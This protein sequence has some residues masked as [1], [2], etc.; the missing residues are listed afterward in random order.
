[1]TNN[2]TISI[3]NPCNENWNNMTATE[4]GKFCGSCQKNV[5]DFTRFS[6]R[7]VVKYYNQNNAVCG[8]FSEHQINRTLII[9]KEKKS[10]WTVIAASILAFLGLGNQFAEAQETAKIEQTEKEL[11]KNTQ[12]KQNSKKYYGKITEL[13]DQ[14]LES[15]FVKNLNNQKITKTDIEGKFVIEANEN[16]ILN[17]SFIGFKSIEQKVA[18][19]RNINL[20]M[21]EVHE[22][23][24][25][26]IITREKNKTPKK[27][28]CE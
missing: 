5:I 9:P 3:P 8:R 1:M 6:D 2:I 28:H 15:V 26:V 12:K 27:E 21:K 16:D 7:E 22:I 23:M 10:I 18:K 19:N 20:K 17:F 4:K 25:E 14:P 11:K 24:G 13:N